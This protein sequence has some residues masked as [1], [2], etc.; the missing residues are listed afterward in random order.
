MKSVMILMCLLLLASSLVAQQERDLQ[1]EPLGTDGVRDAANPRI[2]IVQ[3]ISTHDTQST[4]SLRYVSTSPYLRIA[5]IVADED[6]IAEVTV[7]GQ[8]VK[9]G[10]PSGKDL[11]LVELQGQTVG[12]EAEVPISDTNTIRIVARDVAG[13]QSEREIQVEYKS[14]QGLQQETGDRWAVIIGVEN[15]EDPNITDLRYSVDD[16]RA[17]YQVLV[18]PK[19]GGFQPE[20]VRLLTDDAEDPMLRP[21]RLN[22]LD[23]LNNWLR[24]TTERDTVLFYFSGHGIADKYGRNYLVA[25]DSKL[26]LLEDSA[27][28]MERVNEVLDDPERIRARKVVAILDSCHSGARAGSKGDTEKGQVLDPFFTEADGRLTLASCGVEEQSFEDEEI[29]HGVF[30]HYLIQ[31]M[32]GAGDND[33]D[34]IITAT[35]LST[36]VQSEVREWAWERGRQQ[37]PRRQMNI[38][39]GIWLALDPSHGTTEHYQQQIGKLHRT[40]KLTDREHTEALSLI[41]ATELTGSK[42]AERK[43][44]ED[45]LNHRISLRDYRNIIGRQRGVGVLEVKSEPVGA[46]LFINGQYAGVTP[47][48]EQDYPIGSYKIELSKQGYLAQTKDVDVSAGSTAAVRVR[49]E[50]Q[51]QGS[52][53]LLVLT[54]PIGAAIYVDGDFRGHAPLML[55]NV[56]AGQRRVRLEVTGKTPYEKTVTVRD[57]EK[58]KLP[59]TW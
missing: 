26:N 29:G 28:P 53:T 32:E 16:A 58:A 43:A 47:Y 35:E 49:L 59:H 45:L 11:F 36:Y 33:Q 50:A 17:F 46:T 25:M 15:Y 37:T 1:L 52:G 9:L 44:L 31:G 12:F 18:D 7:N 39:G 56:P 24:Q 27:I 2:E 57:G 42:R 23:T 14:R 13:N 55:K 6:G 38:S 54:N 4:R 19:R 3:P 41:A 20:H 8:P 5:G 48:T 40:N 30:T 21:T 10:P 34:G 22:V 51:A